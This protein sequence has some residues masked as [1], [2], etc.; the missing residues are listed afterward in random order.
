[1]GR[2]VGRGEFPRA[3]LRALKRAIREAD[4][5]LGP[6]R[7]APKIEAWI[8]DRYG[9][10]HEAWGF[11]TGESAR[12]AYIRRRM[13]PRQVVP[14]PVLDPRPEIAEIQRTGWK[15]WQAS[16]QKLSKAERR[17]QEEGF[18]A[19]LWFNNHPG[20]I[21]EGI[22][23]HRILAR[24][25]EL[26][27]AVHLWSECDSLS[28]AWLHFDATGSGVRVERS[29]LPSPQLRLPA[30]SARSGPAHLDA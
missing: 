18:A 15:Q 10:L 29:P 6:D 22:A 12:F 21:A 17:R 2:L 8:R 27:P 26:I 7:S 20:Q 23:K 1:M 9:P 19:Q 16:I 13:T 25:P 14:P 28:C 4:R 11:C 30:P 24:Q 3:E 5:L